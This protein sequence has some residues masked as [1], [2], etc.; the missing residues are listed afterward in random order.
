MPCSEEA[1]TTTGLEV[2]EISSLSPPTLAPTPLLTPTW[3]QS[4]PI[5]LVPFPVAEA[6]PP[7]PPAQVNPSTIEEA[8]LEREGVV[9]LRSKVH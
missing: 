8:S 9:E 4:S 2:V 7:S 3:P 5:P 1:S 6:K